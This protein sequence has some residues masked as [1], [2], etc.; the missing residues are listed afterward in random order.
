MRLYLLIFYTFRNLQ[1][2]PSYTASF[3]YTMNLFFTK[4]SFRK[5]K[6]KKHHLHRKLFANG[7]FFHENISK[8]DYYLCGILQVV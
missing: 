5:K 1:N 6:T 4:D 3:D 8:Y 2:K 7:A